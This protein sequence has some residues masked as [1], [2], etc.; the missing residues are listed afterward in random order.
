MAARTVA[1]ER[2][3]NGGGGGGGGGKPIK[4]DA[5][6]NDDNTEAGAI[7]LHGFA[8]NRTHLAPHAAGLAARGAKALAPDLTSLTEG[9]TLRE[10]WVD[11]S[12]RSAQE[13]NVQHVVAHA[14]WLG[15]KKLGLVGH[16]AGGAVALEAAVA[17]QSAGTPA[18]VLVLI[19][20][21]PWAQTIELAAGLD[22]GQTMVVSIRCAPSAWNKKGN[23]AEALARVP[24]AGHHTGRLIDLQLPGARHGDAM[25]PSWPGRLLGIVGSGFPAICRLTLAA[26]TTALG[27]AR[28]STDDGVDG[29][30]VGDGVGRSN[31]AWETL[32]E[33]IA[34][35]AK[36][37]ELVVL[38]GG[39]QA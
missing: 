25:P 4:C 13:R 32:D 24:I 27:L 16:S 22:L 28:S 35:L 8:G 26:L 19:D 20:A 9:G 36:T 10:I 15:V 5:Y 21:V 6:G 14:A 33:A 38:G 17:L 12:V 7:F 37:G 11:H 29:G 3:D 2:T 1:R 34:A 18:A 31:D 39:D 23:V 30:G